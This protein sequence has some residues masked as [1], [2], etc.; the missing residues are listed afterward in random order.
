MFYCGTSVLKWQHD[1]LLHRFLIKAPKGICVD[2]VNFDTYDN[3]K[4]NLRL[5]NRIENNRHRRVFKNNKSGTPG[6]HFVKRTGRWRA[7]SKINNQYKNLGEFQN[8]EDAVKRRKQFEREVFQEYSASTK[9]K[10]PYPN[11]PIEFVSILPDGGDW[12]ALYMNGKLV[13]EGH[14]LDS[15]AVLDA[16]ADA[17]PNT[18]RYVY[19]SDEKAEEG[20]S[21]NLSDM[22]EN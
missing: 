3:R 9:L 4:Q 10:E 18:F 15:R 14:S 1:R 22:F 17:V 11:K 6:V 8:Y 5:C 13:A 16:I 12:E 19:V 2:H 7:F 20:F 21:E